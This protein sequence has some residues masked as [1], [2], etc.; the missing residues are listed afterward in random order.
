MT[1]LGIVQARTSSTRL[2]RKVLMPIEG[3][4]MIVYQLRRLKRCKSLD[5]L[6]LATSS[7]SSDDEL[8][9]IVEA[10]GFAVYRGNLQDVLDRFRNCAF[11]H[12]ADI[13]VRLTGDC[14]FSDPILVDELVQAFVDGGW[15]YLANCV[16]EQKLSVPDGFDAEVFRA[17]VLDRAFKEARLQSQREHVTPWFRTEHAG[18]LW[19]HF[20]HMPTRRFYRV[21]VDDPEDLEVVRQ[22]ASGLN[23]DDQCFGVDAVVNFLDNHPEIAGRNLLTIRNAGYLRSLASDTNGGI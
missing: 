4:P 19:G 6:V 21:T 1:T 3:V 7:D 9:S 20:Q 23:N 13:I 22:I 16:D 12:K 15:D 11:H 10:A 5:N 18:L 8:T 2:P 17:V 14:P